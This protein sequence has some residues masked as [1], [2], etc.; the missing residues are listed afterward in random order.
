MPSSVMANLLDDGVVDTLGL[1]GATS[2]IHTSVSID[3]THRAKSLARYIAI[4][5][6]E[7]PVSKPVNIRTRDRI[8]ALRFA[9]QIREPWNVSEVATILSNGVSPPPRR[10]PIRP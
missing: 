3:A 4:L 9:G 7:S 6:F 8:S 1:V 2:R 5:L 10:R